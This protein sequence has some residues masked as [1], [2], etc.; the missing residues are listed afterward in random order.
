MVFLQSHGVGTARSV[1]IYKTYG[2]QAIEKVREN[3][4]RLALDIHGIGFKTADSLAEH[5]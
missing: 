3:L 2:N 1:R 4:Y 5:G